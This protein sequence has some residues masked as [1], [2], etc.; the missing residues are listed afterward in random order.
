MRKKIATASIFFVVLREG[1]NLDRRCIGKEMG[2][3]AWNA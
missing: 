3:T 2:F 1:V